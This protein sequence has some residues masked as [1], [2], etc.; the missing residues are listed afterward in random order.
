M[1]YTELSII[2]A[3]L[4]LLLSCI[5]WKDFAN[6]LVMFFH[7]VTVHQKIVFNIVQSNDLACCDAYICM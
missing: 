7:F 3:C 5:V 4:S 6:S 1:C 2:E